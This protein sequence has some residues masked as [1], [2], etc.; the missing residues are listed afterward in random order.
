MSGTSISAKLT[1][2]DTATV[3]S[4][5]SAT[6]ANITG[7][8]LQ[9]LSVGVNGAP[10]D[11]DNF[12]VS[13]PAI[14][15]T[16][17]DVGGGVDSISVVIS[18][19]KIVTNAGG[20]AD[21][22]LVASGNKTVSDTG[23]GTETLSISSTVPIGETSLG[24]D[25]IGRI[26]P[27]DPLVLL[28]R[29]AGTL[30]SW[31]LDQ[32]GGTVNIQTLD[33]DEKM[34][35][36]DT[37]GAGLVSATRA[38]DAPDGIYLIETDM[39]AASGAIGTLELLDASNNVLASVKCDGGVGQGYFY[40]DLETP[41]TFTW[42]AI[43]YKMVVLRIDTTRSEARCFYTTL[44]GTTPS[45]WTSVS[46]AKSFTSGRVVSKIRFITDT[47]ATGA[48]R[49]DEVKI[50]TVKKFVLGD[51]ITAGHADTIASWNPNP[52]DA[53]RKST[54]EDETPSWPYRPRLK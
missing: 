54:I 21:S 12:T 53:G 41:S 50:Y 26:P 13:P 23:A 8:G 40:T 36:N 49:I 10:I 7:S 35:L 15:K 11:Y 39:Y 27:K 17:I 4:S 28:E 46:P 6:D 18:G 43:T 3:I 24:A 38:F 14:N 25:L 52:E 2:L 34:V 30:A 33:N 37:S 5:L 22:I 47:A 51:S 19:G 16:A 9:C 45:N 1:N 42:G 44:N 32:T 29:F 31:T 48:V 20:G